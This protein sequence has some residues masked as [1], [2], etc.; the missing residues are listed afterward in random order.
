MITSA[1]RSTSGV[2]ENVASSIASISES[3]TSTTCERRARS[4]SIFE[5]SESSPIVGKPAPWMPTSNGSP[6]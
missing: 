1:S 4:T 6:T 5:V 3:S 2:A